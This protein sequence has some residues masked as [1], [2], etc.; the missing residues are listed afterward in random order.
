[1]NRG[2]GRATVFFDSTDYAALVELIGDACRRLPMRVLAFCLMPNHFHLSLCPH[3]DGDLGRWM[4][5]LLTSH[6]RRHHR[7]HRGSG[8][9]WQGRLLP[10]AVR[11][12]R[13]DHG[14]LVAG[15]K[16][17]P[18]Q[19]DWHLLSVLRYIERN[20]LRAKLVKRAEQWPWSS[21][22]CHNQPER[23]APNPIAFLSAG[24]VPRPAPRGEPENWLDWVNQP[25]SEEELAALR[26]SAN[27]GTPPGSEDWSRRIAEQLGLESTLR[28]RGR[29]RKEPEK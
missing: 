23:G 1:M 6:V 15:E 3:E 5:W 26:R 25:Q 7:R 8:H 16:A 20:P 28:P 11:A 19:S 13:L 29:P 2:N 18:A 24:P 12:T 17:F 21:L 14:P 22:G 27:R 4:Q 10:I 9:V